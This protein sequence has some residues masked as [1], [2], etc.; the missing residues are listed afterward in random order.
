MAQP[1]KDDGRRWLTVAQAAYVYGCCVNTMRTMADKGWV[2][3][4][5]T[6][7]RHRRID[8]DSLERPNFDRDRQVALEILQ[9]LGTR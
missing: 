7:G 9:G 3:V 1:F 4:K 5:F 8:R 2:N 6:P